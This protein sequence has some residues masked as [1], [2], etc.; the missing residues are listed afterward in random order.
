MGLFGV[1]EKEL[2]VSRILNLRLF[3]FFVNPV[4]SFLNNLF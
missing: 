3:A 1:N 4:F 2:F